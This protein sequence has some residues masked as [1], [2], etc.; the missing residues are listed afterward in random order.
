LTGEAAITA[1]TPGAA[2]P[3][4]IA[5]AIAD[6]NRPQADVDLDPRRKP[7]EM[8]TFVGVKSDDKVLE[9]IPG[10][11]WTDDAIVD[12]WICSRV[13]TR[14]GCATVRWRRVTG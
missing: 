14:I 7:A 5:G 11:G 13:R 9:L 12:A 2:V 8:L 3:A 4:N 1:P 6:T 10:R